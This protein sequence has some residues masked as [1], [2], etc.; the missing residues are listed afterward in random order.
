LHV[1]EGDVGAGELQPGLD[2]RRSDAH[3]ASTWP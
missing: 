1:H 2:R 3:E